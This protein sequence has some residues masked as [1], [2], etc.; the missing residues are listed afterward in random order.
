VISVGV[1]MGFL[2]PQVGRSL[3]PIGIAFIKAMKMV[4]IP[5][6]FSA[7]VIGLYHITNDRK[8]FGKMAALTFGWFYFASLSCVGLGIVMNE[9]VH[10]GVGA[11]L[12]A[13]GDVRSTF[14]TRSTGRS[15]SST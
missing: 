9:L 15:S 8:N 2:W 5:L 11:S 4:I 10:P 1:L 7:V 12:K 14:L 6:V 3:Q 13:T